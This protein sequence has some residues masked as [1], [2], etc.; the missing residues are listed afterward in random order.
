MWQLVLLLPLTLAITCSK[1]GCHA[2]S[3]NPGFGNTCVYPKGSDYSL[4]VCPL[5]QY[6]NAPLLPTANV[7]CSDTP[8]P[9][10]ND[11][12]YP[13]EPCTSNA[14]C[15]SG[16]CTGNNL[17]AGLNE[18]VPCNTSDQCNAGLYC[19]TT[20]PG[21]GTC[22][23][24][25]AAGANCL[26][27]TECANNLGCDKGFY[28]T[29]KGT[30][31]AYYSKAVGDEV[32][33]CVGGT[34]EA[35]NNLCQSGVCTPETPGSNLT[36]GTCSNALTS[37][38]PKVC[39]ADTDCGA[40]NFASGTCTCGR[41]SQG[42]A[43]CQPYSGDAPKKAFRETMQTHLSSPNISRCHTLRRFSD[44]CVLQV[45]ANAIGTFLARQYWAQNAPAL[46]NNDDCVKNIFSSHAYYYEEFCP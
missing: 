32:Q 36:K 43:Y 17:C 35:E 11:P 44:V 25:L 23:K 18:G 33:I 10:T 31:T 26:A 15:L 20:A 39:Q 14:N 38:Y 46:I 9:V 6:C 16:Q 27:D 4:Q 29:D 13:G 45:G 28:P 40:G 21:V 7:T 2:P 8:E 30:C 5:G 19:K 22:A 41:N 12:G 24:Q 34:T 42:L 1:Y 3:F 37:S